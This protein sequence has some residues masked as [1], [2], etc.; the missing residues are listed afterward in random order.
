[1]IEQFRLSDGVAAVAKPVLAD[2]L[3]LRQM[4]ER[5]DHRGANDGDG[6]SQSPLRPAARSRRHLPPGQHD[7]PER[8]ETR[9]QPVRRPDLGRDDASPRPPA[10]AAALRAQPGR[11]VQLERTARR[12]ARRPTIRT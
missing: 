2:E 9:G 6:R 5:L 8:H 1:V 12:T 4:G 10:G 11:T 7:L 3:D